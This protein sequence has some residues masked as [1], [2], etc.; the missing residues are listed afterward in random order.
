M[1][2]HTVTFSKTLSTQDDYLDWKAEVE[3]VTE[4]APILL[5][6][7]MFHQF[8]TAGHFLTLA[9][10]N[11]AV[12][13][14]RPAPL[15]A[16]ATRIL[17]GQ[18]AEHLALYTKHQ[19]FTKIYLLALINSLSPTLRK[20]IGNPEN[21]NS[22]IMPSQ[23]IM[24]RMAE[25]YG[26][27]TFATIADLKQQLKTPLLASDIGKFTDH[28]ATFTANCYELRR[29]G[30][31]VNNVDQIVKFRATLVGQQAAHEAAEPYSQLHPE[32]A[33]ATLAPLILYISNQLKNPSVQAFGYANAATTQTIPPGLE[34]A[35]GAI[36]AAAVAQE[37]KKQAG[38][39]APH[40]AAGGAAGGTTPA[41]HKTRLY[42][43]HHGYI[44]HA[45]VN[46][47]HML[48]DTKTFSPAM[49]NSPNPGHV[50]G[51]HQ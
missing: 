19:E 44:G 18:Y 29:S 12:N 6:H 20:V 26:T 47:K 38:G 51:G 33:G 14:R 30:N 1:S 34:A 25:I 9:N 37:F 10:V 42:C 50:P 24:A 16:D 21:P 35:I 15:A 5:Y 3:L 46:C 40:R 31:T 36:V 13:V 28:S 32:V 41:R 43:Y 17:Q 27:H 22:I 4:N 45:G 7:G 23:Q 48:A 8:C 2:T 11:G 39:A 49:V